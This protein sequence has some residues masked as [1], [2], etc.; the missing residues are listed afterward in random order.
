MSNFTSMSGKRLKLIAS[1]PTGAAIVTRT[2]QAAD[3]ISHLARVN[4]RKDLAIVTFSELSTYPLYRHK[5]VA[6][7]P[8]EF[9]FTHKEIHTIQELKAGL[10]LMRW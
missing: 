5:T 10:M 1:L 7:D 9:E 2:C 4:G 8:E 6:H 3:Y